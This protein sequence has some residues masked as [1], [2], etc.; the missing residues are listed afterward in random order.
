MWAEIG[1]PYDRKLMIHSYPGK[2]PV[3][4][5]ERDGAMLYAVHKPGIGAASTGKEISFESLKYPGYFISADPQQKYI[6][7]LKPTDEESK[8]RATFREHVKVRT[9]FLIYSLEGHLYE[10]ICNEPEPPFPLLVM[11]DDNSRYFADKCSFGYFKLTFDQANKILKSQ[12]GKGIKET[13]QAGP[14]PETNATS[15]APGNFVRLFIPGVPG[16]RPTLGIKADLFQRVRIAMPPDQFVMKTPGLNGIEGTYSLESVK[17]PM[18]YLQRIGRDIYLEALK[19]HRNFYDSATFDLKPFIGKKS[20]YFIHPYNQPEWF[21]GHLHEPPFYVRVM[22]NNNTAQ[23]DADVSWSLKKDKEKEVVGLGNHHSL[24]VALIKLLSLVHGPLSTS[25]ETAIFQA[26]HGNMD[27]SELGNAT[28]IMQLLQSQQS[29]LL[30]SQLA[31]V[32]GLKGASTPSIPD[33]SVL[34]DS[35][36]TSGSTA[37]STSTAG[38]AGGA[39]G[40]SGGTGGA[41]GGAGGVVTDNAKAT[42]S[43][44]PSVEV[45]TEKYEPWSDWSSCSAQCG[46]GHQIRVRPCKVNY[47]S[48]CAPLQQSQACSAAVPCQTGQVVSRPQ[49]VQSGAQVVQTGAAQPY[50]Q[51]E[52]QGCP[53]ICSSDCNPSSCP[54]KCCSNYVKKYHIARLNKKGKKTSKHH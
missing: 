45:V 52:S 40:A 14:V 13:K 15:P 12:T 29:S 54:L 49:V 24:F 48:S 34:S 7:L 51:L 41:S 53:T 1:S 21:L 23:F 27:L 5:T 33:A 46:T 31:T 11:T 36:S 44:K 50:A 6:K 18:F 47:Q 16:I 2:R 19:R 4:T 9:S 30:L 3:L 25:Q 22:Y 35:A 8:V 20:R 17:Y 38:A 37:A 28:A 26:L 10:F 39:G 42:D 32:N 43:S